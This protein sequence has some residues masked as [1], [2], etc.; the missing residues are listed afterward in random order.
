MPTQTA[1]KLKH[2][3]DRNPIVLANDFDE[4]SDAEFLDVLRLICAVRY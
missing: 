2:V 3:R 4:Y 1:I